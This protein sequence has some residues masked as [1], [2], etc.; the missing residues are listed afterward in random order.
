[1]KTKNPGWMRALAVFGLVGVLTYA[2]QSREA[3]G[4]SLLDLHALLMVVTAPLLVWLVSSSEIPFS[5]ALAGLFSVL[6]E[7]RGGRLGRW[8]AE[9]SVGSD[10]RISVGRAV[11]AAAESDDPLVRRASELLAARYDGQE[12]ATLLSA[13]AAEEEESL[14]SA[15][16]A[17][18]FLAKM[19]PYFGMLATVLGMIRLLQNLSDFSQI[20]TGMSLALMGTLYGLGAYLL[21][22]APMQRWLQES[23]RSLLER[24]EVIQ[25][26][27]ALISE[28]AAGDLLHEAL[29]S[30]RM[31]EVTV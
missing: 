5:R 8:L 11:Q 3:T 16:Y 22:Y 31:P 23:H 15:V 7:G 30:R 19:S 4:V 17:V 12:L 9:S 28:R 20:S 2:A 27:A 24:Q 14:A 10:G 18:G 1:M 21:L 26:W 29:A 6:K 13:S 25:R